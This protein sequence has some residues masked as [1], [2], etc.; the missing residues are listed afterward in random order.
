MGGPPPPP[1]PPS[2]VEILEAPKARKE[3]FGL[4]WLVPKE[5]KQIVDLAEGLEE[6]LAQSFT[7]G[8]VTPQWCRVL[9]RSPDDH[10]DQRDVL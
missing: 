6:K 10:G 5:P 1:G 4:N 2:G 8:G 3:L 7:G 9:K